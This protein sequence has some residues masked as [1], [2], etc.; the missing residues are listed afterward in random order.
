MCCPAMSS[1]KI[2]VLRLFLVAF[3]KSLGGQQGVNDMQL[4]VADRAAASHAVRIGITCR[5]S[6]LI[7]SAP[8]SAGWVCEAGGQHAART[9]PAGEFGV[10]S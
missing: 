7:H 1:R 2:D 8:L 6:G 10:S 9:N 5:Q 4:V 3:S